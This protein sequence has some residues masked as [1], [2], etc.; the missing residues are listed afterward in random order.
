MCTVH[1][2]WVGSVQR[3]TRCIRSQRWAARRL[4]SL[5]WNSNTVEDDG[6]GMMRGG[7][8][9]AEGG[10]R[11]CKIG[12]IPLSPVRFPVF[13]SSHPPPFSAIGRLLQR[14]LPRPHPRFLLRPV[15]Y[16]YLPIIF[17]R[18]E[19]DMTTRQSDVARDEELHIS[20]GHRWF[21]HLKGISCCSFFPPRRCVAV[22]AQPC[23]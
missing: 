20:C 15:R 13:P 22:L 9:P 11:D 17:R 19:V 3:D 2:S 18:T 10:R 1:L 7:G 21:C 23:Q 14:L 5:R 16:K 8:G 6:R 4:A 12:S